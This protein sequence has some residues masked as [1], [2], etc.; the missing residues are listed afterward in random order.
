[1]MK[2]GTVASATVTTNVV[3]PDE[4]VLFTA[5]VYIQY[6][7]ATFGKLTAFHA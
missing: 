1:M 6:T 5:G 2:A 7:T 4:G 3:I